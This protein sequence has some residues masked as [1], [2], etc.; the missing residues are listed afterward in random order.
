MTAG[1]ASVSGERSGSWDI[2]RQC[3]IPMSD[4]SAKPPRRYQILVCRGPECGP[5]RGSAAIYAALERA[6]A[7]RGITTGVDL[8]WQS[9][10]GRCTRGPNCLV[11]E[12]TGQ[13]Q[14]RRTFA[15]LPRRRSGPSALYNGVTVDDAAEIVDEHVRGGRIVRRLL[16]S[17]GDK[18][19]PS[20]VNGSH[21]TRH[22]DSTGE[23][24]E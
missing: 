8:G 23:S 16:P 2:E 12:T 10:F 19:A 15:Q 20:A 18:L 5:K 22:S 17:P 7:D 1:T 14:P 3:S 24:K 11:R 6:L 9:C 13:P 21:V 4:P